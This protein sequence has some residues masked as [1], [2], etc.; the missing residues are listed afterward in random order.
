MS[1][2]IEIE[3]RGPLGK[4][5]VDFLIRELEK[6]GKKLDSYERTIIDYSTFLEGIERNKDI[7]LRETNGIPEIIVKLGKWGGTDQREE[8]SVLL[9]EGEFEKIIGIFGE[10]GLTKGMLCR[11]YARKYEYKDIEFAIVEVPDH[12]YYFEAEKLV[13]K[14]ENKEQAKR[15]IEK[16]LAEFELRCFDDKEFFEYIDRLNKEANR[17]FE[18][19]KTN[20][21]P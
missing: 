15:E 4:E 12:S 9:K 17:V 2:N 7:R 13:G 19:N 18:Y 16:V 6:K 21:R 8:I 14:D 5:K 10:I 20:V 1:K 11:R 3:L